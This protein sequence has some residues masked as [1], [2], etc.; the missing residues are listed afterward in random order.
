M[1]PL[2]HNASSQQLSINVEWEFP[3]KPKTSHL[4]SISQHPACVDAHHYLPSLQR[5]SYCFYLFPPSIIADWPLPLT[6]CL[7]V[8]KLSGVNLIL[9]TWE[10]EEGG[11][12]DTFPG[13]NPGKKELKLSHF[14][15]PIGAHFVLKSNSLVA[16]VQ[17]YVGFNI[18]KIVCELRDVTLGLRRHGPV[19]LL[20]LLFMR[21]ASSFLHN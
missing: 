11:G 19:V 14:P 4:P 15:L 9:C 8:I 10:G 16:L 13:K 12:G 20:N 21:R 6:S 17:H 1:F 5:I 18:L 2:Q 3:L 7:S